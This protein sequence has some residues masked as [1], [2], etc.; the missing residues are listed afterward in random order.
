[1]GAGHGHIHH[2]DGTKNGKKISQ[3][4]EKTLEQEHSAAKSVQ[5]LLLGLENSGKKTLMKQI[6]QLYGSGFDMEEKKILYYCGTK[7]Y[8]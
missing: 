2:H 7:K 4:I 8:Y 1:M 5:V 6:R 3:E